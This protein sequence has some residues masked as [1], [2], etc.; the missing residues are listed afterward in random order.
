MGISKGE[1]M[2]VLI[3]GSDGMLGSDLK[4]VLTGHNIC[5][6]NRKTLDVTNY[7]DFRKY[8]K[9]NPDFIIHLA[10]NTDLE[11]C[12][13]NPEK[14]YHI[15]HVGTFNAVMFA[16]EIGAKVI[17]IGTTNIFDGKDGL[18][19]ESETYSK[20]NPINVYGRSKLYAENSVLYLIP[21]KAWVIRAGWMFGGGFIKEK[22]FV[23][24][25]VNALKTDSDIAVVDDIEGSM[26]YTKDVAR[27]IQ[28][29]LDK[30]VNTGIYNIACHGTM[31]RYKIALLVAQKLGIDKKIKKVASSFFKKV[32]SCIRPEKETLNIEK[33]NKMDD[34]E[35]RSWVDELSDYLEKEYK[36]NVN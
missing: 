20:A 2:R 28:M 19:K 7:M 22:K 21:F 3:T 8:K 32:Y 35:T 23:K 5:P 29:I 16:E 24:K 13:K 4:K 18:Y 30:K 15:N 27:F 17:F 14:A 11:D 1:T 34:F 12:K 36:P 26:T 25:I 33:I 6:T 9:F 10:T 31:T